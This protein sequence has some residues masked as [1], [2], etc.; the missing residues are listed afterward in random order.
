ME[1][2]LLEKILA[3]KAAHEA[4]ERDTM[5]RARQQRRRGTREAVRDTMP[6]D[7]AAVAGE[8]GAA[9]ESVKVARRALEYGQV[10]C[11]HQRT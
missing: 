7:A 11:K 1:V 9:S 4:A 5:T 3:E 2:S 8:E 6:P 10:I